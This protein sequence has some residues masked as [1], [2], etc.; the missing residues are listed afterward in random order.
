MTEEDFY[1]LTMELMERLYA[2]NVIH[3][4]RPW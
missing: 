3:V 4:R 2:D 1:E